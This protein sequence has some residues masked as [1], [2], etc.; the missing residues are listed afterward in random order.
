MTVQN[1]QNIFGLRI[2][3]RNNR[4][5][6]YP[7]TKVTTTSNLNYDNHCMYF[8]VT[9]NRCNAYVFQR[10]RGSNTRYY[11]FNGIY[12][13]RVGN[14]PE[15]KCLVP[16]RQHDCLIPKSDYNPEL[17]MNPTP[18]RTTPMHLI[19]DF[20]GSSQEA[21]DLRSERVLYQNNLNQKY[22]VKCPQ[23]CKQ[24]PRQT[25]ILAHF[26]F[27]FNRCDLRCRYELLNLPSWRP[28]SA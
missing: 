9:S 12:R 1:S 6:A 21:I 25:S 16:F 27:N 10:K 24:Q 28:T 23:D 2:F 22:W 14:N 3:C 15:S 17:I 18:S 11:A 26:Y 13:D 4:F 5:G 19:T 7:S 8:G 20:E